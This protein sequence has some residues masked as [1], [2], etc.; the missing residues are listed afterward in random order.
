[1]STSHLCDLTL[2]LPLVI[3]LRLSELTGLLALHPNPVP[4]FTTLSFRHAPDGLAPLRGC[5]LCWPAVPPAV[6]GLLAGSLP[7]DETLLA[8]ARAEVLGI[9]GTGSGSSAGA[10]AGTGT[11]AAQSPS[12]GPR[13]LAGSLMSSTSSLRRADSALSDDDAASEAR[14]QQREQRGASA[15]GGVRTEEIELEDLNLNDLD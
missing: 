14:G 3:F 1:M 9:L 5:C 13:A 4:A 10:G 6:P 2:E 7:V 12:S 11:G 15:S 8:Q